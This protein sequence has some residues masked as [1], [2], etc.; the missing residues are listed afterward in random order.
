M[1]ITY[2][3]GACPKCRS[4]NCFGNVSVQGDRVLR[5]CESCNYHMTIFLPVIRKKILYLDQFFLSNAFLGK[6]ERFVEAAQGIRKL[7]DFQ[8]L[9]V[10]FSSIHE[11]ETHQW[12]GFGGKNKEDLMEF[13]KTSSGGHEFQQDYEVEEKQIVTAFQNYMEGKSAE[14]M[15][16]ADDAIEGN[17]HEWDDY[18][19]IDVGSYLGD[20][21]VIR[22]LKGKSIQTLVDVFEDWRNSTSTFE[23]DVEIEIAD[24]RKGYIQSYLD[25]VQRM[26]LGDYEAMFDSPV[27][28]Q[29]VQAMLHCFTNETPWA[30]RLQK[31]G[32]FFR[33]DHFAQVPYQWVSA[34]IYAKLKDMVKNEGAYANHEKA[35]E[36]LSG[37]FSDVKHVA[38]YSPYCDAFIMDKAMAHLVN[39][40]RVGLHNRYGVKVFSLNNWDELFYWL[41]TLEEEMSTAHKAAL[42]EAY[43]WT[44]SRPLDGGRH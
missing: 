24:A 2:V 11:D 37:F 26:V 29:V 34:R 9:V 28:S 3:L 6:D 25:Y 19:R 43:P 13:V 33:S 31:V 22:D 39:D 1:L 27:K 4:E 8:L 23:Q 42:S 21:Q 35:K 18:Y 30:E 32:E 38:I 44:S 12:K 14:F 16:E 5:G 7:S 40:P 41:N 36:R 10:P 20:I 17:I 15:L